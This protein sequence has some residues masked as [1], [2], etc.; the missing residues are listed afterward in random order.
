MAPSG[1]YAALASENAFEN[2][3]Q[4]VRRELEAGVTRASRSLLSS[5]TRGAFRSGGGGAS[6]RATPLALASEVWPW[7]R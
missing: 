2:L 6:R 7:S 3:R 4:A 5:R 1:L